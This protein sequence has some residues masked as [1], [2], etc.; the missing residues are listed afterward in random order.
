MIKMRSVLNGMLVSTIVLFTAMWFLSN[1]ILKQIKSPE[2]SAFLNSKKTQHRKNST[3]QAPDNTSSQRSYRRQKNYRSRSSSPF[4]PRL[5]L[6]ESS[7][8]FAP[9]LSLRARKFPKWNRKRKAVTYQEQQAD[10]QEDMDLKD[11]SVSGMI[12]N[13]KSYLDLLNNQ[14]KD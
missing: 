4:G 6:R 13:F 11:L 8:P 3:Q 2:I 10:N 5:S 1:S 12:T 7:N 14:M 9:K